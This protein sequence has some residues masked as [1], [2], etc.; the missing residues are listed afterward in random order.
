M[1]E[2]TVS[3]LIPVYNCREYI[4]RCWDSVESQTLSGMEVIYI[5]D[6]GTD[7]SIEFL[8]ESLLKFG[9]KHKT[10]IVHHDK[11]RGVA[12]ARNTALANAAGEYTFFLDADDWLDADTL[13]LMY[14]EGKK[15]DAD[16]IGCDQIL[17]YSDLTQKVSLPLKSTG[18]ENVKAVLS[19]DIVGGLSHVM[20]R[21]ALYKEADAFFIEGADYAED[22]QAKL[23][24]FLKTDRYTYVAGSFYHYD[25]M[26]LSS[27]S[28]KDSLK[29]V[30][31]SYIN[32]LS[33]IST[34]E[35]KEEHFQKDILRLKVEARLQVLKCILEYRC[36]E[37]KLSSVYPEY[38]SWKFIRI[39]RCSRRY[40][41][42]LL[43]EHFHCGFL[44]KFFQWI[45]K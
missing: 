39:L 16:I 4:Q 43:M 40:K 29:R 13:E 34:L 45:I 10:F 9:S 17:H 32:I 27:V 2:I 21:R 5:D 33:M 19:N 22:L 12:A 42:F 11:N 31:G 38:S 41:L 20:I 3:L 6:R 15:K 36:C 35:K 24:L 14:D 44:N 23:K 8:E 26:N 1:S 28:H 37:I 25:Q 18:I 30:K 7:G